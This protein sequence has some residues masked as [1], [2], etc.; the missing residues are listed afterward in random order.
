MVGEGL[1][2]GLE[3]P[4]SL[5]ARNGISPR[6]DFEQDTDD[7]SQ[8]PA[9]NVANGGRKV[10]R[11]KRGALNAALFLDHASVYVPT[12]E[13]G[14]RRL[15]E[16]LGLTVTPTPARPAQHARIWLDRSYLEVRAEGAWGLGGF[17]LRHGD[18][19]GTLAALQAR[20]LQAWRGPPY[21][22]VDGEW[23]ELHVR[24]AQA[25]PLPLL[26]RRVAPAGLAADWPPPLRSVHSG[27]ARALVGVELAVSQLDE[28]AAAYAALSDVP[29]EA[30]PSETVRVRFSGGASVTL[31]QRDEGSEGVRMVVL[32]VSSLEAL[33]RRALAAGAHVERARGTGERPLVRVTLPEAPRVV[34]GAV[35]AEPAART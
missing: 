3:P 26:V 17:F 34:W 11:G 9:V 8:H 15:E 10:E 32:E 29:I 14:A 25:V 16:V 2:A 20:G 7:G 31:R 27:G 22:G 30:G 1:V 24:A 35:E 4:C 6:E 19:A 13:Q 23:E 33:E 5:D 12:L 28:A 21:V 18:A